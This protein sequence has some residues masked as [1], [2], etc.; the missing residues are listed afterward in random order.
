M[1]L[2]ATGAL[3]RLRAS[4]PPLGALP[5]ASY[6]QATT[7]LAPG[8]VLIVFT[9][10]VTEAANLED[11]EFGESRLEGILRENAGSTVGTLC[12]R[13]VAAVQAFEAGLPQQDD[14]T[15]VAARATR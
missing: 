4:G 10:G 3:E 7:A 14:I 6:R 5:T 1:L 12:E 2:R 8:D 13:I 11:E 9:D 15:V